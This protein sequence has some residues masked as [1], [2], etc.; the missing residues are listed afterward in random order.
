V[1]GTLPA[2]PAGPAGV[3]GGGAA[4]LP[5]GAAAGI[6][7]GVIA[8]VAGA[9]AGALLLL[10]ARSGALRRGGP[11]KGD[12]RM[13]SHPVFSAHAPAAAAAIIV[14]SN[15][16]AGAAKSAA[17]PEPAPPE[18]D[19]ETPAA[20]LPPGWQRVSDETD[21]WFLDEQGVAHWELPGA[22]APEAPADEY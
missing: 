20:E 1:T 13:G 17:A 9:G 19:P 2:A 6:S 10:R 14:N 11:L 21:E 16:L 22:A 4:P 7:V 18:A 8:G 12:A 3:A 15:P 5:A